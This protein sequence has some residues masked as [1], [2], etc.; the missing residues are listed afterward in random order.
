MQKNSMLFFNLNPIIKLLLI[1]LVIVSCANPRPPTGGPPDKTPP[2]VIE[3]QPQNYTINFSSDKIYIKFN[4]WVDRGSVVNNIYFNPEIKYEVVWSGKKMAIHF[5]E[6]L[7]EQTTYSFFLGTNYN[8]LDGNK[9]NEPFSLVFSTGNSLDSGV[10][11]GRIISSKQQNIFIFAFPT[12]LIDDTV[13][14]ANKFFHYRTQPDNNGNFKFDALRNDNYIVFAFNDINNNKEFDFGSESFGFSSDFVN[15][16]GKEKD[17]IF[18]L[19]SPLMDNIPPFLVDVNSI[20]PR[21]IKLTFSEPILL[22]SASAENSFEISD[23]LTKKKFFPFY[24][25]PDKTNRK[26]LF[27]FFKEELKESIFKISFKDTTLLNDTIGNPLVRGKELLFRGNTNVKDKIPLQVLDK[28]ITLNS[29]KEKVMISFSAPLDTN[30]S[31]FKIYCTNLEQ[32]DTTLVDYYFIDLSEIVL[33]IPN[34][35]W[36]TSYSISIQS[37]SIFDYFG[38]IFPKNNFTIYLKIEDEPKLGSL[39]GLLLAKIDTSFGKP[40]MMA[41]SNKGYYYCDIISNHWNFE[42]IPEDEYILVAFYDK[43][44]NGKYD[45]GNYNPMSFSEKI[46]KISSK[47]SV[48]KGWTV[49]ELRF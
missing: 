36:R 21:T 17:T 39:K 38:N 47:I 48:K 14:N 25:L 8:D 26:N 2:K 19:L 20:S 5:A 29:I 18:I 41:L 13:F 6:K 28:Q 42:Q 31:K 23:T 46:I 12:S 24:V 30:I 22:K 27:A 16:S 33:S 1:S 37:D 3:Y 44:N 11:S 40:R 32:K 9:P 43:N 7:K 10:V 34:L 45:G 49:E 35:K 4:K 15:I